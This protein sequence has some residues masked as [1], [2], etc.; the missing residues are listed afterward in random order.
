MI[1]GKLTEEGKVTQNI[2][3]V[4]EGTDLTSTFSLEDEEGRFL[5]VPTREEQTN[6][7]AGE[8]NHT[9]DGE[10]QQADILRREL[11]ALTEENQTLK[12]E[13]SGLKRQLHDEKA[14]FRSLWRTNCQCLAEYDGVILAKECEIEELKHQLHSQ[15]LV[16]VSDPCPD[17]ACEALRG[18]VG[19]PFREEPGQL[20]AS[21]VRREKP[22]R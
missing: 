14:Q 6:T 22:R 1:D 16:H 20:V 10:E 19:V 7:E 9:E 15:S 3:V 21:R 4:F 5:T 8:L 13:V 12:E 2:Q 11:Q 18:K 17:P